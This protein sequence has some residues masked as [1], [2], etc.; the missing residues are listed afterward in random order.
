MKLGALISFN[1]KRSEHLFSSKFKPGKFPDHPIL[2][3]VKAVS[4]I[5]LFYLELPKAI[6][7]KCVIIENSNKQAKHVNDF[8][9]FQLSS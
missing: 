7:N 1:L 8:V 6:F 2:H 9:I 4:L 5:V 3:R